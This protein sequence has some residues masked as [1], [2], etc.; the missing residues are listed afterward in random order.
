MTANGANATPTHSQ[1]LEYSGHIDFLV[2]SH[3]GESGD[4]KS[5]SFNDINLNYRNVDM[6][7]TKRNG[8]RPCHG[9]SNVY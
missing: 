8:T 1:L 9:W 3:E 4:A 7:G 6:P 5:F 2:S